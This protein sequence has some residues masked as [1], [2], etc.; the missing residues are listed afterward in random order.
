MKNWVF[1]WCVVV[2]ISQ[3]VLFPVCICHIHTKHQHQL[4]VSARWLRLNSFVVK[5]CKFLSYKFVVVVFIPFA[6]SSFILVCHII[7]YIS[8]IFHSFVA[9]NKIFSRCKQVKFVS[10][11]FHKHFI[12]SIKCCLFDVVV[13]ACCCLFIVPLLFWII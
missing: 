8:M 1:S 7:T 5:Q 11:S 13:G 2:I 9:F 3:Q 10:S 6:F 4:N 12:S